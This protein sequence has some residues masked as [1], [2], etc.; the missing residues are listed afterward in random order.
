MACYMTSRQHSPSLVR[1]QPAAAVAAPQVAK[2]TGTSNTL[3]PQSSL[4]LLL[5]LLLL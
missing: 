1:G 2:L 3:M 4:L 5:L